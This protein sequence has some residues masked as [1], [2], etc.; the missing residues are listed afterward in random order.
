MGFL[1]LFPVCYATTNQQTSAIFSLMVAPVSALLVMVLLNIPL[2]TLVPRLSF[3]QADLIVVFSITFIGGSIANEWAWVNHSTLHAYPLQEEINPTIREHLMPNLPDWL[4]IKDRALVEDMTGGGRDFWYVF[5]KLPVF[6]SRYVTWG[7]LFC[8]V[9]FAMLCINSLMRGAW[10]KTERL[11]FPTIQLPIAMAEN[12]G[13]GGMWKSRHMWIAFAVM[14]GIDMLNGFNYLYPN[15]PSIP[16]KEFIDIR[17]LFTEPPLSNMGYFPISIFPFMAAIGLFMPSNLLFSLVLFFLLRKATHVAVAAYGIPQ[18]TFSGTAI[19][20][21]P[22]YFDE[23]TWGAVIAIFISTAWMSRGYLREVWADI[24]TG[25]RSEDGGISHRTAF[26]GL[27]ICYI[28]VIWFGVQGDLPVPFMIVYFAL[29]LVFSVVL[30]RLRAQL[31]PPTH[32]FAFFGPNNFM[33][34]FFGTN[35]ITDKQGAWLSQV[36]LHFNRIHRTHPM[37]Y[38]LETMKMT[39]NNRLN[40]RT[41]FIA[42]VVA[43]ILAFLLAYF[44][45]HVGTYRLGQPYRWGDGES[46]FR[47]IQNNR[48]GPDIVGISMTIFGFAMVMVMDAIRFRFPA[49]PVHPAGYVLSMNFGVDYYWFGLLLALLTKNFV[50]RYYGLRGYDKLRLVALGILLG[51]YAAE[52]IWMGMAIVTGQSTYTISF[53]D[54]GLGVQ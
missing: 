51:E 50:T 43:T 17:T 5:N 49:F 8:L 21:G 44:F 9:V 26:V 37:P 11:A 31:G 28:G 52:T 23:Q 12:G 6:F 2:R 32:E 22:P 45:L 47:N 29:L 41:I 30:T 14:F 7:V 25:R 54:R 18:H 36:F 15:L 34:R 35:W 16:V 3:S 38:Q 20:P 46:Y 24:K 53:N 10:C 4:I 39:L 19:A 27:L 40:Q 1:L 42:I 33:Y 13:R 48:H